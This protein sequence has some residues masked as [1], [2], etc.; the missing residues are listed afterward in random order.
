[1]WEVSIIINFS[2]FTSYHS[3]EIYRRPFLALARMVLT[4]NV[5]ISKSERV[6]PAVKLT[7]WDTLCREEMAELKEAQQ[8]IQE[9]LPRIDVLN[10]DQ[11]VLVAG[12]TWMELGDKL[13]DFS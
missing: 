5:Y 12:E 3:P 13:V 8:I 10:L 9:I 6:K 1:M 4:P 2:F 11:E 7:E